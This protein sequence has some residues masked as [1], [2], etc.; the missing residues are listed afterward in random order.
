MKIG[1]YALIIIPML[2]AFGASKKPVSSKYLPKNFVEIPAGKVYMHLKD[3]NFLNQKVDDASREALKK[4]QE[5]AAGLDSCDRFYITEN[6]ITNGEYKLF[7]GW[8]QQNGNTAEYLRNLPDTT[9]WKDEL[10]S[11]APFVDYYL[12]HPAYADYP[13]VGITLEQAKAYCSWFNQTYQSKKGRKVSFYIPTKKE[14]IRAAR[15]ES[16]N[17]Y[18]WGGPYTRNSK[19]NYLANFKYVDASQIQNDESKN[20]YQITTIDD[21]SG[22]GFITTTAKSY[23]PNMY[24]AYNMSGNVAELISDDTVAMGGSWN[25]VGYD[26]RVESTQSAVKPTSTIG[27]RVAA[28]IIE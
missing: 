2:F 7:L 17:I 16:T 9:V 26:I 6:E 22:G 15:G 19:G 20:D 11:F 1:F 21:T 3:V 25:D 13:L 24:G 18:P 5:L 28:R 12:Q 27:F 10:V 8:L 23:Y 4:K 14:W